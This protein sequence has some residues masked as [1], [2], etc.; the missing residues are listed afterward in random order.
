MALPAILAEEVLQAQISML[1]LRVKLD[2]CSCSW[3]H[4]VKHCFGSS[5]Y[6]DLWNVVLDNDLALVS[7]AAILHRAEF[8]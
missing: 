2:T 7:L 1:M 6:L 8:E 3:D 5:T 4:A